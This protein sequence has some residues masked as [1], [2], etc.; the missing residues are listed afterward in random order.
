MVPVSRRSFTRTAVPTCTVATRFSHGHATCRYLSRARR[1][2]ASAL[3]TRICA[4][5]LARARFVCP[6][7]FTSSLPYSSL[8]SAGKDL[9][10]LS[11]QSSH[12]APALALEDIMHTS[13]PSPA[14]QPDITEQE[15]SVRRP[16]DN[17]TIL[18]TTQDV[19]SSKVASSESSQP[20][21]GAHATRSRLEELGLLSA[22]GTAD[23][24]SM[25]ARE[26]ELIEMVCRASTCFIGSCK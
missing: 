10:V 15:D 13:S 18:G 14:P 7:L 25:T 9:Q 1:V 11:M 23:G 17:A 19:I 4:C 5:P 24:S 16:Q 21:G 12:D 20:D 8:R 22:D 26:K 2:G 6:L 3:L